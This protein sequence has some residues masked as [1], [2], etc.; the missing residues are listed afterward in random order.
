MKVKERIYQVLLENENGFLTV[1]Q[2]AKLAFKNV[3]MSETKKHLNGLIKRNMVYAIGE[4][5]KN[6]FIIRPLQTSLCKLFCG[7]SPMLVRLLGG[8]LVFCCDYVTSHYSTGSDLLSNEDDFW[9]L[10]WVSS[11][12][13]TAVCCVSKISSRRL[14]S[15]WANFCVAASGAAVSGVAAVMVVSPLPSRGGD[16]CDAHA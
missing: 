7:P 8:G 6:G 3:Y 12:R 1:E 14:A 13:K 2:I 11:A 10:E 5:T 9:A 15:R 16:G 4:L